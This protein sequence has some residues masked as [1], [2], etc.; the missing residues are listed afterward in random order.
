MKTKI[1]LNHML[2][3]K[4]V[5]FFTIDHL[6]R[7]I[8]IFLW[9][10]FIEISLSSISWYQTKSTYFYFH[11]WKFDTI[12]KIY[13]YVWNSKVLFR[14]SYVSEIIS[15]VI[16]NEEALYQVFKKENEDFFA[17]AFKKI[18]SSKKILFILKW[19]WMEET[20]EKSFI[21]FCSNSNLNLTVL[22]KFWKWYWWQKLNQEG[23][24]NELKL[25]NPKVIFKY[26]EDF[27]DNYIDEL[28]NDWDWKIFSFQYN[29]KWNYNSLN[30][31]VLSS[32]AD[33]EYIPCQKYKN[34]FSS[35]IWDFIWYSTDKFINF[36]NTN[37]F[38]ML[39][40]QNID[41]LRNYSILEPTESFILSWWM[42]WAR[43]FNILNHLNWVFKWIL[44]S[45]ETYEIKNFLSIYRWIQNY[46][47]FFWAFILSKFCVFCHLEEFNNDDRSKMIATAI[48]SWKPVVVPYNSW[49]IVFNIL[50]FSLWVAYKNWDKKDFLEKVDFFAKS[51]KNVN[52]YSKNCINYSNKRM[53]VNS[54]VNLIFKE[55]FIKN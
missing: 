12:N 16:S 29:Y 55:N 30:M 25:N 27:D 24:I 34:I 37:I 38:K 45:D 23:F 39:N 36:D 4:G 51:E 20:I 5:F 53:N 33:N 2:F 9:A 49:E 10:Y 32:V 21:S 41:L 18:V 44:I 26:K 46:Y 8:V 22:Y 13:D 47:W 31:I 6:F 19:W 40:P 54:F 50:K 35:Y 48:C 15:K 14:N 28:I 42:S 1:L 3:W 43:N 7:K 52:I 11:V 17:K